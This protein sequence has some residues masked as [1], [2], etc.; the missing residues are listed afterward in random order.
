M[1]ECM[2]S[3]SSKEKKTVTWSLHLHLNCMNFLVAN[4][5]Q[6]SNQLLKNYNCSLIPIGIFNSFSISND[7]FEITV[8]WAININDVGGINIELVQP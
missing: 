1:L 3:I 2:T 4:W 6:L 5:F 7:W 8:F